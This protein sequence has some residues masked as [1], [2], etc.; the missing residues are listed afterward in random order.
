MRWG[1]ALVVTTALWAS[2]ADLGR[3]AQARGDAAAALRHYLAAYEQDPSDPALMQALARQ[4]SDLCDFQ[5]TVDA[6]RRY[7]QQALAYAE[8]A[9]RAA[10]DHAEYVLSVAIA[11]GK[12]CA[13]SELA[14]KVKYSRTI[15]ADAERAATLNPRYAWAHH[16]IGRWN[17][18][19]V[20]LNGAARLFMSWFYGGLPPA[21]LA[22]AVH[23]LRLA[24]ELE[25]AEPVHWID[26]GYIYAYSGDHDQ[27]KAC[28]RHGLALPGGELYQVEAKA[29]ARAALAKAG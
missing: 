2:E 9:N 27:A 8:R 14:D 26:L 28:W 11:Y 20:R 24:T 7:A 16:V 17:Y 15:L 3:Q 29:H 21:S 6:R 5:P 18:E 23:E 1:I 19:V 4:Y 10:P 12:L 25:P 13:T 22:T